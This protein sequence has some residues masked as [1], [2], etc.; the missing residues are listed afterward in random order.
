MRKQVI[1]LEDCANG[2]TII[3]ETVFI[4]REEGT[5]DGDTTR[6]RTIEAGNEPG[7]RSICHRHWG[8]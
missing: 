1:S 3:A 8:R 6:V 7:E 5:I 4:A 2:A